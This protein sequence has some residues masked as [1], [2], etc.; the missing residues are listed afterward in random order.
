MERPVNIDGSKEGRVAGSFTRRKFERGGALARSH[1]HL[2]A[3]L[4]A[5][6]VKR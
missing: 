6:R 1:G 2:R 5:S 4:P 3:P